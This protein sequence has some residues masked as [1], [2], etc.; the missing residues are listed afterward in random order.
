MI[1][2]T[3]KMSFEICRKKMDLSLSTTIECFCFFFFF[4]KNGRKVFHSYF[5]SKNRCCFI[6]SFLFSAVSCRLR[7][8]FL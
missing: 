5:P 3:F 1:K 7:I 8:L 2:E 4:L 6:R